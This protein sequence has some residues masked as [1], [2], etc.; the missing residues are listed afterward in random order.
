MNLDEILARLPSTDKKVIIILSGGMDSTISMRLCVEKYG[1][2]NVRA[3][4]FDY[5]QKQSIEQS[6]LQDRNVSGNSHK[7][8]SS[9]S[10]MSLPATGRTHWAA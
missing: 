4:T 3:L 5:G 10:V 9:D 7:P 6:S 8:R 2:E 1:A